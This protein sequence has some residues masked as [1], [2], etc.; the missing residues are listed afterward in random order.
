MECEHIREDAQLVLI[1][2]LLCA[3]C[4]LCVL[5]VCLLCAYCVL[6]PLQLCPSPHALRYPPSCRI[7]TEAL[8]PKGLRRFQSARPSR[9]DERRKTIGAQTQFLLASL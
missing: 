6:F 5:I 3:Y 4:V 9:L 2:C 1:V 7:P 8:L